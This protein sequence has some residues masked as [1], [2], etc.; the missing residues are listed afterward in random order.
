MLNLSCPLSWEI[1]SAYVDGEREHFPP[2][3]PWNHIAACPI[4]SEA[5]MQIR[6][7]NR[8]IRSFAPYHLAPR[9]LRKSI[10]KTVRF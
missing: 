1:L 4:C 10:A 2:A 7:Q 5:C 6:N 9:R 8:L 3:T